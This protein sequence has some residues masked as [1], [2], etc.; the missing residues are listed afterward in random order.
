MSRR[1]VLTPMDLASPLWG[2]IRQHLEARLDA[3]RRRND[4]DLSPADT[5]LV[6]GEIKA[7]K[8]LLS[9]GQELPSIPAERGDGVM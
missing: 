3:A 1:F 4:E 8:G 7:L 2:R 9:L 6:R 5:A